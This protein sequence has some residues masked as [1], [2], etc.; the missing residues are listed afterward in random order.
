MYCISLSLAIV[1]LVKLDVVRLTAT[2]D[3]LKLG[4]G[5]EA[6]EYG[7]AFDTPNTMIMLGVGSL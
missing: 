7:H 3:G 5:D 2:Q 6:P 4:E 1:F